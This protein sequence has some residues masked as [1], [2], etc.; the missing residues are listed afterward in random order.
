MM[1][2]DSDD[3]FAFPRVKTENTNLGLKSEFFR[4]LAEQSQQQELDQIDQINDLEQINALGNQYLN[5]NNANFQ[6]PNSYHLAIPAVGAEEATAP[7]APLPTEGAPSA[8]EPTDV[9]SGDNMLGFDDEG[10]PLLDPSGLDPSGQNRGDHMVTAQ[11]SGPNGNNNRLGG[12]LGAEGQRLGAADGATSPANSCANS[13]L[14]FGKVPIDASN[15][16]PTTPRPEGLPEGADE[17]MMADWSSF[18]L[19]RRRH[20]VN[21]GSGD[22]NGSGGNENGNNGPSLSNNPKHRHVNPYLG[23]WRFIHQIGQGGQGTVWQARQDIP[24]C[25]KVTEKLYAVKTLVAKTPEML[26]RCWR[27]I[28]FLDKLQDNPH[29]VDV[30]ARAVHMP[31]RTIFLIMELA[32]CDFSSYLRER[33]KSGSP[34]SL[35]EFFEFWSQIVLG[36]AQAHD[37]KILHLDLKP[38][39]FLMFG[40]GRY[41]NS[42]MEVEKHEKSSDSQKKNS[43]APGATPVPI[44]PRLKVADFGVAVQ[45][46][47][48]MTHVS[49]L[50]PGGTLFYRSPES[51]MPE[52]DDEDDLYCVKEEEEGEEEFQCGAGAMGRLNSGNNGNNSKSNKSRNNHGSSASGSK[53]REKDDEGAGAVRLRGAADVWA[54]GVM[55]YEMALGVNPFRALLR[56]PKRLPVILSNPNLRILFPEYVDIVPAGGQNSKESFNEPQSHQSH[57]QN[58][59]SVYSKHSNTQEPNSMT[60]ETLLLDRHLTTNAQQAQQVRDQQIE[61]NRYCKQMYTQSMYL[62]Q[63][64]LLQS[65]KLRIKTDRLLEGV[66]SIANGSMYL[67]NTVSI[68]QLMREVNFTK[69]NKTGAVTR[70]YSIVPLNSLHHDKNHP[71][72]PGSLSTQTV[73]STV[74]ASGTNSGTNDTNTSSKDSRES[75]QRKDSQQR[76]SNGLKKVNSNENGQNQN[77]GDDSNN[78]THDAILA[79]FRLKPR[80]LADSVSLVENVTL[81]KENATQNGDQNPKRH[82]SIEEVNSAGDDVKHPQPMPQVGIPP[83]IQSNAQ[84]V[85]PN[86]QQG[87]FVPQVPMSVNGGMWGKNNMLGHPVKG[88]PVKPIVHNGGVVGGITAGTMQNHHMQNFNYPTASTTAVPGNSNSNSNCPNSADSLKS[89]APQSQNPQ[90]QNNPQSQGPVSSSIHPSSSMHPSS[91]IHPSSSM[92]PS[93]VLHPAHNELPVGLGGQHLPNSTGQIAHHPP[94]STGGIYQNPGGTHTLHNGQQQLYN[95]TGPGPHDNYTLTESQHLQEEEKKRFCCCLCTRRQRHVGIIVIVVGCLILVAGIVSLIIYIVWSRSVSANN[96]SRGNSK[97]Y[98]PGISGPS[99]N[100][101]NPSFL[102]RN[103]Q[104]TVSADTRLSAEERDEEDSTMKHK[105]QHSNSIDKRRQD[106]LKTGS[107]GSH[108]VLRKTGILIPPPGTFAKSLPKKPASGERRER[109]RKRRT[110]ET[111]F[112]NAWKEFTQEKPVFSHSESDNKKTENKKTEG[113][114]KD[115]RVEIKST[116]DMEPIALEYLDWLKE[117]KERKE[118]EE[119]KERKGLASTT[120]DS[121][122]KLQQKWNL[123]SL[124]SKKILVHLQYL[125]DLLNSTE[126]TD[127]CGPSCGGNKNQMAKPKTKVYMLQRF[128]QFENAKLIEK[129]NTKSIGANAKS[130]GGAKSQNKNKKIVLWPEELDA[131]LDHDKKEL[132]AKTDQ[133]E[134]LLDGVI[135]LAISL[136]SVYRDLS[137][138]EY[139]EAITLRL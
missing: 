41:H 118:E 49:A 44:Y 79:A 21:V 111:K 25:S 84:P 20:E 68:E 19:L 78:E 1:D 131:L 69:P 106:F 107:T 102:E 125:R 119:H 98:I 83:N 77:G 14:K 51:F 99:G 34:L 135:T 62:I 70:C 24:N 82:S 90:S 59:G 96:N 97:R 5:G 89:G 100:I 28:Q 132:D 110:K 80:G 133:K 17:V 64:C 18:S 60:E 2:F 10:R 39:N 67:F 74:P 76:D 87:K 11:S 31:S 75:Q 138:N 42:L 120:E 12:R 40:V 13:S 128:A 61:F 129:E 108:T 6:E 85:Q 139:Y 113:K 72:L 105:T 46:Q 36:V 116:N 22:G 104:V 58:I 37:Q 112:W 23:T 134:E 103:E 38:E 52:E 109:Q 65:P 73:G 114:T 81:E 56:T 50:D 122:Q 35:Q 45:V 15:M 93:S 4:T 117:H 3:D 86:L 124:N 43:Q 54:V 26:T 126:F 9:N 30:Y 8:P 92:R 7:S 55:G 16:F 123:L 53:S 48:S 71:H 32:D 57:G 130:I 121:E 88:H 91:S 115:Q 66:S 63:Q 136:N 101:R 27:E 33:R 137:F 127:W 29:V 95:T 94:N 47:H